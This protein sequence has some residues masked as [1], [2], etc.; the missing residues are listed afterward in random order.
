MYLRNADGLVPCVTE[1]LAERRRDRGRA[2]YAKKRLARHELVV[3]ER[4]RTIKRKRDALAL[5]R[6]QDAAH[7]QLLT[8]ERARAAWR[9]QKCPKR[10]VRRV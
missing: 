3:T 6:E 7:G 4:R 5:C 9:A 10:P 1:S 2:R 8:F